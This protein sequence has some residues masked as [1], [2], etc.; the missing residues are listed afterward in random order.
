MEQ[1]V[2]HHPNIEP[3]QIVERMRQGEDHVIV[4]HRQVLGT[5]GAQPRPSLTPRT[6]GAEAVAAT[7]VKDP[8]DMSVRT[9]LH[10]PPQRCRMAQLHHLHGMPHVVGQ[11]RLL[12]VG[13]I[14]LGDQVDQPVG[15][16][17]HDLEEGTRA[18]PQASLGLPRPE[19]IAQRG[20]RVR[21][22]RRANNPL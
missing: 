12:L 18:T 20:G 15:R 21:R 8:G 7:V 22:R 16:R 9:G 13:R 4:A 17:R 5:T 1:E 6:T 14:V 10:V 2:A 3:P 11:G 19:E